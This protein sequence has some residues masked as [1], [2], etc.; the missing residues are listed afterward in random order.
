MRKTK[1][2]ATLGPSSCTEETVKKLV[3]A[4]MSTARFNFSHGDHMEQKQR[5][6]VLKKVRKELWIPVSAMMDTKGPEVRL[7]K[8]RGGKAALRQG[9][10]FTLTTDEILGDDK[11]AS[12]SYK[13][14]PRDV[15]PGCTI[16]LDDG[17]IELKVHSQTRTTIETEI[18]NGGMIS[19]RKG[20]NLPGTFLSMPYL[21]EKDRSDIAFAV[22]Q[23]FDFI[24]ASFVRCA[25][26]VLK[27]RALLSVLGG[28]QIK[29]IAKIENLDGVQN[30]DEIIRVSD[31][32]MVAR[33]DMGVEIPL[34][35]VPVIQK[36]LIKQGYRAGKQVITATQMLESMIHNPRPTRAEATDVANAIY[37]G[38]SAIMLSGETAA[39]SYPIEAVETMARIAERAENDIDYKKRFFADTSRETGDITGAIAH[40]TCTT[41]YD[42]GAAAIIA[43]SKSGETLKTISKFR[44]SVPIVGC[45]MDDSVLRQ[46]NLSWGVTPVKLPEQK[47]T[48]ALFEKAVK[49]AKKAGLIKTGQIAVLVAGIPLGVSGTTNMIKVHVVD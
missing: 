6:D 39:G 36:K 32:I 8:F 21:S 28:E 47:S 9:Q 13:D 40:A 2:V 1:I 43:V 12:I 19:D 45:A 4:G 16:L 26:D 27:I 14:L 23:G 3:L 34:E 41:A 18:I 5:L 46:M 25:D 35:D 10:A 44:P 15:K 24:A 11:Q 38:T 49:V 17:L 29:I 31:G 48:D 20:V 33:G 37:D 7:G 30:C 42:V 22:E